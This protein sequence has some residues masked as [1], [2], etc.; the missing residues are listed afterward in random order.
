MPNFKATLLIVD[1]IQANL[2]LLE[3]LLSAMDINV[4][5][6]EDGKMALKKANLFKPDLILLDI[7]MPIQDGF[8]VC[9]ILKSDEQTKHI[10]VIFLTGKDRTEDIIRGFD[11]GAVDY[12]TKPFKIK[13]L[14]AR[15]NTHLELKYSKEIIQQQNERL[16]QEV[17]T[18]KKIE[19]ELVES[20]RKYSGLI[21]GLDDAV[22]RMTCPEGKYEYI[23]PAALK[24]FGYSKNSFYKT[25][26]FIDKILHPDYIDY[27]EDNLETDWGVAPTLKYKIIDPEGNERWIVQANKGTFN[28]KGNLIAIEGIY[29]NISTEEELE[30]Q[31]NK[32]EKINKNITSSIRYAQFIQQAVLP[33]SIFIKQ[34]IPENF[35]LYIPRDIVSG[36][37]YWIKQ[38][39]NFVAVAAADCTGH[40]VPGAF[41]SMLGI[42]LLNEIVRLDK[43]PTASDILNE[44][45]KRVKT[46]LHQENV[47]GKSTDGMDMSLCII[48]LEKKEV[49]YAGA[50]SPLYIINKNAEDDTPT[51]RHI[52][53][54]RMPVGVYV[55][56]R[57]FTN[58]KISLETDDILYLFSD[59]YIDQFGGENKDKFKTKRFKKLL[60]DIYDKPMAKQKELLFDN[61]ENWRS[62]VKQLDDVLVLGVKIQDDYGDIDFF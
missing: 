14:L 21:T 11:V 10:P 24:V 15:V 23:S 37:F 41:M 51:L 35:I 6:A 5:K 43:N 38:V 55:K 57:S 29:R 49:Q 28:K 22:F 61:F 59:G 47:R 40:G 25:P 54:D 45:R 32:L 7:I 9:E 2:M 26:N 17:H 44:L 50:N 12:I 56:E 18:R 31:K 33:N 52:K 60:I 42:A 19:K 1:D 53:P 8:E 4:I 46:S 48:D 62:G 20:E 58:H 27:Y 3:D 13:E 39:N 36:D 34:F 30:S 16:R